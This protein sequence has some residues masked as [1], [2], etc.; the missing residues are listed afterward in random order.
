MNQIRNASSSISE[1][2]NLLIN[3]AQFIPQFLKKIKKK[4]RTSY[5]VYIK[6]DDFSIQVKK[7]FSDNGD[8][9]LRLEYPQLNENSVVFDL[10][11]YLGDFAYQ[12]NKKYG[13]TVY[14]F[15]PH[16]EF[17]KKC[18]QRFSENPKVKT[19]CYG[20]SEKD[21]FFDLVDE[22]N[23]SSFHKSSGG[24]KAPIRCQVKE[25]RSVVSELGITNIDL[26]KINIE[27]GEYPLM[28]HIIDFG[29]VD[30]V[31]E[32]QIQFHNFIGNS[33]LKRNKIIEGL[34]HS[35]R[36]TWCYEF[37]WENWKRFN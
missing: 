6:K 17:S 28:Q 13:C 33:R 11:G 23:S 21:G 3:L 32:Y 14:I 35:H 26:M 7:W 8:V 30:L 2:Q 25:F 37:V 15:E 4:V 5:L 29:I 34:Q 16:P 10:G 19:L 36:Q 24:H 9:T 1:E 18:V 27:G 12:I 20:I 22:K 31:D